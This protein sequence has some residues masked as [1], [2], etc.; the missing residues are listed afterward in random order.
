MTV[1]AGEPLWATADTTSTSSTTRDAE[2]SDLEH[3]LFALESENEGLR[4]AVDE[5]KTRISKLLEQGEHYRTL[6]ECSPYCIHEID[7]DRRICSMNRAGLRMLS[8][9]REEEICG[10]VYVEAAE[11]P[12][13]KEIDRL[14]DEAFAGIPSEFE[15]QT[16]TGQAFQSLF[17]PIFAP[18]GSVHRLMGISIDITER[19]RDHTTLT[20]A[21]DHLEAEVLRQRQELQSSVKKAQRSERLASVGTLAAGIAHQ[22]N[23][24]IGAILTASE[25]ALMTRAEDDWASVASEVLEKNVVEARRCGRIVRDML[26][27]SREDDA[28]RVVEDL[29][30]V[31]TRAVGL[32]RGYAGSRHSKLRVDLCDDAL[33]IHGNVLELDQCV[34]NLI[35]NA[36][37]SGSD[38]ITVKIRVERRG[39]LACVQLDDDGCGIEPE[40]LPRIFDPFFTTRLEVSGTGLG[41]SIC[42]RVIESHEGTIDV[43][44]EYGEGSRFTVNLPLAVGDSGDKR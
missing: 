44:S 1:S 9:E 8:L 16:P 28:D 21:R 37:E 2:W 23:N 5:Q 39:D 26:K 36:L 40:V 19:S 6:V 24:S 17:V 30:D 33:P 15:F 32:T 3:R 25:F 4:R 12:Y 18:D 35:R 22:I 42:H 38:N 13:R 41:L 29:R 27:F 11:E 7:S 34:L 31:V 43:S 14:M 20:A 10:T